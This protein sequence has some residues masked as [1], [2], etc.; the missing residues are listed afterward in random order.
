MIIAIQPQLK[1]EE[2]LKLPEI[3]PASELIDGEIT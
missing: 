3:K 2:F 1:L